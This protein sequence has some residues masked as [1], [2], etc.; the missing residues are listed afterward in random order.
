MQAFGLRLIL[1]VL[2]AACFMG[3][4]HAGSVIGLQV[5]LNPNEGWNA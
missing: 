1:V 5:P 2:G 3:I 4:I